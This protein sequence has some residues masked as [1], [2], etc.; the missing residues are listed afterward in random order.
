MA[1][2]Q[3]K[4]KPR[5]LINPAGTGTLAGGWLYAAPPH[6]DSATP[7]FGPTTGATDVA[8]AGVA[9]SYPTSL[10]FSDGTNGTLVA[11]GAI[12]GVA[13]LGVAVAGVRA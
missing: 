8:L 1:A 12:L 7:T 5:V 10:D 4:P 6:I 2:N 3:T 13:A 11:G 9:L